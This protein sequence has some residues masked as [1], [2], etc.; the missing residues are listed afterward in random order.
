MQKVL[1]VGVMDKGYTDK[2]TGELK[3]LREIHMLVKSPP[4]KQDDFRGDRVVAQLVRFD[5]SE[6]EPQ[7]WY[8]PEWNVQRYGDNNRA[9]LI[10]LSPVQAEGGK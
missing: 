2:K 4:Q 9:E 3:R 1:V 5:V 10:G 7:R 8:I 6:I